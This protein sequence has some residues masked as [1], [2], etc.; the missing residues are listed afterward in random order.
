[1]DEEPPQ[2]PRI[3]PSISPSVGFPP[4]LV[5][6]GFLLLGLLLDKV[7]ALPPIPMGRALEWPGFALM[8]VGIG[9]I[10]VSLGMFSAY[11]EDPQPW[12]P[13]QAIIARGPYRHS[14]NPMY[15]GMLMIQLGYAVWDASMGVL[16][17]VPF[18]FISIDRAV[19]AKEESYLRR[20]FGKAFE[21]YC[22][23]VRRWI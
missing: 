3:D 1:M 22:A 10:I 19:I 5:F 18:A 4:P 7:M 20:K 17:F 2:L 16:A 8:A 13:S 14:R 6:L 11:G 23:R 9:L 12:T 15:L 21:D